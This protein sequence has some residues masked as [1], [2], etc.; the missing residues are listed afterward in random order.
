TAARPLRF[1]AYEIL[2][3]DGASFAADRA[4]LAALAGWGL[5]IPEQI[6]FPAGLDGILDYHAR[7]A[8]A[9]DR[10]P[11]EIDGI[12]VKADD[13]LLR[14][15]MG[16]TSH[17]PRWALAFKFEPRIEVTRVDGIVIQVGRTGVMTPVALLRPV[18][19]GG[20]TV[21][22]ATLHNREEVARRD[23]RV[24]DKVRVHRAGDVIP[25]VVERIRE[26]GR[27]R[28]RPFRMSLR[29][30]SCG[31][32]AVRRGPQTYCPNRLGCPAQLRA[33]LVHLASEHGFD[34]AGLGP[35]IAA[36]LVERHLVRGPADLFHLGPDDFLELPGFATRSARKLADAI[37]AARRIELHR[38]LYALGLPGVGPVAARALARGF[39]RLERLRQARA[40]DLRRTAGLGPVLARSVHRFF[41]DRRNRTA[42][43]KLLAAGV[44]VLPERGG[45]GPL[46]GRRFVFTGALQ[47]FTR[48]EARR[49]VEGLGGRVGESVGRG[50]HFVV[51]GADPGRKLDQ[52]RRLGLRTLSERE[53]AGMLRRAGGGVRP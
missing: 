34:I 42:I 33:R 29:C 24:G 20:V 17:H 21:S 50:V 36:A 48:E 26:P 4:A 15:R 23:I 25:E 47:H 14:R 1:T 38:F 6:T 30:P 7:L 28:R 8:A 39:Q 51:V 40:E 31:S 5:A 16:V 52:A 37:Q 27:T 13:L 46:A 9:R 3:A 18:D 12:V 22:R 41:S 2:L 19:V 10:L 49:Q 44:E 32:P 45:E 53:L 43:A 35:E 11:V